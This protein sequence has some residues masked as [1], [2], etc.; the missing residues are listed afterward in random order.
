[1]EGGGGREAGGVGGEEFQG[2]SCNCQCAC[3]GQRAAL[4]AS[5]KG[6]IHLDHDFAARAAGLANA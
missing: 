6:F 4:S 1:M 3:H 2:Y 5:A